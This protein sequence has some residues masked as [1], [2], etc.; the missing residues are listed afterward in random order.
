M[1]CNADCLKTEHFRTISV[2]IL[3]TKTELNRLPIN[4]Y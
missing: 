3:A 1:S 4:A 2:V